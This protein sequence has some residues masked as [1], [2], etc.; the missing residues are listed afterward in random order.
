MRR[1][2]LGAMRRSSSAIPALERP[3]LEPKPLG[4]GSRTC[5]KASHIGH[6]TGTGI[7]SDGGDR[8]ARD[9]QV[10]ERSSCVR[11]DSEPV[12]NLLFFEVSNGT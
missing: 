3:G 8:Q 6:L 1:V 9:G 7:D 4:V 5:E 12:K 10:S 11:P 2:Y